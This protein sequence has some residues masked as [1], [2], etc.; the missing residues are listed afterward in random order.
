MGH[1][2]DQLARPD[3]EIH[4]AA[5]AAAAALGHE[6]VG[7][8]AVLGDLQAAEHRDIDVAAANHRERRGGVKEAGPGNEVDRLAAGVDQ[9]GVVLA[10]GH[11]GVAEDAVLGLEEDPVGGVDE[12]GDKRRQTDPEIDDAAGLQLAG[13]AESDQ[14]A[15]QARPSQ[16]SQR[17]GIGAQAT[18]RSTNTA[19]V[20][21]R[22][23]AI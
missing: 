22:S 3:G 13:D 4:R 19:G 6:P 10:G 20:P 9:V 21:T 16:P 18:I 5:D 2:D 7:Q 17:T 23:G 8:I 11:A 15:G 12:A 14:F 1:R